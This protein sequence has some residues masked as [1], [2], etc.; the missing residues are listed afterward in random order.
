MKEVIQRV[1]LLYN[2]LL[3]PVHSVKKNLRKVRTVGGE[4]GAQ[5]RYILMMTE[6]PP[7]QL[8]QKCAK[9]LKVYTEHVAN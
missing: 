6:N 9:R 3:G 5:H 2:I 7:E 1:L 8:N 4:V